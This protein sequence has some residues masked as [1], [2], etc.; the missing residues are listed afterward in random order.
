MYVGVKSG[1]GIGPGGIVKHCHFAVGR[2]VVVYL[3]NKPCG[4][5]ALFV[6]K[7]A[8]GSLG[9][10]AGVGFVGVAAVVRRSVA[11]YEV[12]AAGKHTTAACNLVCVPQ[13]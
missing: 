1:K 11:A 2:A 7:V 5:V 4:G 3:L 13:R 8:G 10:N 12:G 6:G 9:I